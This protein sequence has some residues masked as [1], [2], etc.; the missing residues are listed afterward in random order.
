MA[1][2]AADADAYQ[3]PWLIDVEQHLHDLEDQDEVELFDDGEEVGDEY[4]FFLTGRPDA[5]LIEAASRIASRPGVPAGAYIVLN[6]G[7]DDFGIGKRIDL[8]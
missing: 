3:F 8:P 2:A 7:H 5:E 6:T 1:D 4:L